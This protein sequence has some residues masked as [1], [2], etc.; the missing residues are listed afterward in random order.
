MI[1]DV[2]FQFGEFYS[3]STFGLKDIFQ[4]LTPIATFIL[5]WVIWINRDVKKIFTH[6]QM[7]EVLKLVEEMQR[8]RLELEV[9]DNVAPDNYRGKE[10]V[11]LSNLSEF[12]HGSTYK[13]YRK[14]KQF[15]ISDG[16]TQ[17]APYLKYSNHLLIPKS[18]AKEIGKLLNKG[19]HLREEDNEPN[20]DFN[21][22][23]ITLKIK[24]EQV[25]VNAMYYFNRGNKVYY[26]MEGYFTQIQNLK[27][28]I[29]KWLRKFS[30]D[31]AN[32]DF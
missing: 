22:Y 18:I 17:N 14:D 16:I 2:I 9:F 7:D 20:V 15:L 5:A 24:D 28:A 21:K 13:S 29:R 12:M 30:V 26:T 31:D 25:F 3:P 32:F 4:I 11:A 23:Y 1:A 10:Y 8:F 19:D 27:T 6:K